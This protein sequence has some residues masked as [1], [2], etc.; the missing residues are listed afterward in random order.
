M[1]SLS[2]D[3]AGRLMRQATRAAVAVA[4]L[5]IVLKLGA[6]MMT[7][8]VSLLS[9]LADS[10]MDALASLINLFAVRH[11][12]Q[13]ADSEHRFGHGKAEPLAGLGQAAFI[14]ASGIFLIHEGVDRLLSP[15][16]IEQGAVGIGVM[17]FSIAV[18]AALVAYQRAVAR[19]TDSLAIRADS[20]HYATDILVNGG[21]IV[22]LL[23]VMFLDWGMAD[24]IV[25]L[26]IA[27]F[28]LFSAARIARQSLNHLMDRELPDAE[29]ER[30]KE[31]ALG[32]PSVIECHDLKTRAAGLNSFI[33]LHISMDGGL[34]LNAAHEISDAVELDILAAFPH[35]EV[36]IHADPEGVEEARQEF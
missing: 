5:L 11:A 18:T 17:V 19:R 32:H 31:I 21:V 1:K 35:A 12:L 10:A 6:W 23:L 14:C 29:R 4:L 9:S 8:S 24:P 26:I 2:V 20:V 7:G 16:A 28:I 25:A 3:Q 15:R 34:S 30:I 33:Q 13:P 22:S 36:I 27:G